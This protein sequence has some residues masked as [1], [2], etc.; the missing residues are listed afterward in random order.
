MREQSVAF[1][2]YCRQYQKLKFQGSLHRC[3]GCSDVTDTHVV[4]N[5][6]LHI[7]QTTPFRRNV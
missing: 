7:K 5:V 3:L 6:T 4:V 2:E 1:E